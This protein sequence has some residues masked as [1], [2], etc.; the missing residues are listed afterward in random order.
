VFPEFFYTGTYDADHRAMLATRSRRAEPRTVQKGLRER[1]LCANCEQQFGRHESYVATLLTQADDLFADGRR[2]VALARPDVRS[3]RLFALSLIW[4]AS[5]ASLEMFTDVDLGPLAEDIRVRLLNND[6]GD[7]AEY[8]FAIAK[9]G[10]LG[11]HGHMLEAPMR[12][13]YNGFRMYQFMARGYLW[14]FAAT[15][16][17]PSLSR[18]M[19]FVGTMPDL[20]IPLVHLDR[21]ELFAAI[22]KTFPKLF[23]AVRR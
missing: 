12:R 23:P 20:L 8:G 14:C 16:G 11:M 21:E 17:A 1:L 18:S 6:P 19:P 3:V 7:P 9:V 4:R 13:R 5:E 2:G 15:R 10:G 22:R